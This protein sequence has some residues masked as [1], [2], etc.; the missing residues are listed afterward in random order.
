MAEIKVEHT[1]D[2]GR[3]IIY[4]VS[5]YENEFYWLDAIGLADYVVSQFR[6]YLCPILDTYSEELLAAKEETK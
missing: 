5:V 3:E 4:R 1:A 2:G 6:D